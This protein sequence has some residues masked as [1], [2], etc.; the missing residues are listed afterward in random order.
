MSTYTPIATQTLASAATS[1]TF[2]SI[3]Q[4][5]T[6]LVIV[7]NAKSDGSASMRMQFNSDT[8]TN[9]SSTQ[10]SA[11][12]GDGSVNSARFTSVDDIRIGYYQS[13]LSTTDF[14]SC[15]IQLQNYSNSTTNKTALGRSAQQSVATVGLWRNTN[16]ITSIRLYPATNSFS[17]GSTFSLYGIQV[18]NAAAK[19][20][21]G[22]IVTSDGTYMY[23]TFTSSGSFIPSQALTVDYLVVAGGGGGGGDYRAGGGGAGGLRCTVGATGGG[24]SLESA[25]SLTAKSYPVIIGA[26]GAG[27]LNDNGFQGSNSIFGSITSTGGGYGGGKWDQTPVRAGGP[28][29]SG[30]G[31]IGDSTRTA[32]GGARTASPVQGFD[33]GSGYNGNVQC[34]GGGGGAGAVGQNGGSGGTDGDGGAG[35]TTSISGASTTYAGGGGGGNYGSGNVT[36]GGTGGG[37]AG[38]SGDSPYKNG[39]AGTTNLGAGGGGASGLGYSGGNGGNGVVVIRY[40]L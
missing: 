40:A 14:L 15:I 1:V 33:G 36:I 24:G 7:C 29:G 18:G 19:A 26:G 4:G 11:T 2:S 21:G 20:Q 25:L 23:H 31:G 3:P 5:Y 32:A 35:V 13:G 12:T 10:L 6:D 9:Y 34:G 16:S 37:G 39:T 28:G 8:G 27:V 17:S 38:G 22:N 30:G